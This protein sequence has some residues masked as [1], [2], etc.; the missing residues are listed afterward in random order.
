MALLWALMG[1]WP[2]APATAEIGHT[3]LCSNDF[4][5]QYGVF[6]QQYGE[7][8]CPAIWRRFCPSNIE[9]LSSNMEKI[10]LT[11]YWQGGV[12]HSWAKCC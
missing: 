12:G 6:V 9:F 5:Q 1:C 4:V 3:G 2:P 10:N 11:A 8:F 7:D